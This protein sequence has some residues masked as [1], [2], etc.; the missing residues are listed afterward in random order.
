M[1]S[2]ERSSTGESDD[3]SLPDLQ[4]LKP[5]DLLSQKYCLWMEFQRLLMKRSLAAV[6]VKQSQE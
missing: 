6:T 3:E 1:S 5:Y 4:K 2:S